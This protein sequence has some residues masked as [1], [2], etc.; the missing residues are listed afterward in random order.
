MFEN[1][2]V[3][4]KCE[5]K[6]EED[7]KI[8]KKD[9]IINQCPNCK[10]WTEKNEG[11]NHMTCVECKFQWC[12]LCGGKYESNHY[13]KGKRNGL[14][15]YKPKSEEDIKKVLG[16][17]NRDL[18]HINNIRN[19][20]W[21]EPEGLIPFKHFNRNRSIDPDNPLMNFNELNFL[22]KIVYFFQFL[23][24]GFDYIGYDFLRELIIIMM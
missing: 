19:E 2:H 14:Q 17:R 4:E 18:N 10:M 1:W 13:T 7:F 3:K 21:R 5:K 20:Y 12:W 8:W 11:C 9:K 6:E 23:F 24:L 15:F 22:L 16:E